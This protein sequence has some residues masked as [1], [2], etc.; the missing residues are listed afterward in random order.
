MSMRGLLEQALVPPGTADADAGSP[1]LPSMEVI[2]AVSSPQTNAPAP[3]RS[4]DIKV[5][6]GAENV[7]AQQAVFSR[8]IN[9]DLQA[10]YRDGV[11]CADIDV[12]L[13]WRR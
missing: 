12:T 10:L 7:F 3:R 4:L 1:R 11:L 8:L 6:A 5:K 9:G 2:R 13:M